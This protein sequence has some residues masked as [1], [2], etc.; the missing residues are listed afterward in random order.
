M[1][2][3]F[4]TITFPS[5]YEVYSSRISNV[6]R[7]KRCSQS[8]IALSKAR[9][10]LTYLQ[11]PGF[12]VRTGIRRIIKSLFAEINTRIFRNFRSASGE[13]RKSKRKYGRFRVISAIE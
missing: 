7:R 1:I 11:H 5:F 3:L 13:S 10:A 4:C 8:S 6:I 12:V 9:F 2:T